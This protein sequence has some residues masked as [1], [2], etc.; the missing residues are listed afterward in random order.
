MAQP[1]RSF[2]AE[3]SALARADALPS[4]LPLLLNANDL[5]PSAPLATDTHRFLD[6]PATPSTP[7]APAPAKKKAPTH[8]TAA[9]LR[10]IKD[11]QQLQQQTIAV[12]ESVKGTLDD[13][14]QVLRSPE[15]TRGMEKQRNAAM[16]LAKGFVREALEQAQGAVALLPANPE[17]H[18]LLSLSL[19]ANAEFEPS[20]ATARKGLALVDRRQHPLAIECGL[21]HALASL[22]CAPEAIERWSAII[23]ALPLPVLFEQ[24][25]RIASCFPTDGF[26]G[27]AEVLDDLLNRRI[28]RDEQEAASV[29][30]QDR[31]DR[32]RLRDTSGKIDLRPDEIP[33]PTLFAGLDAA[34]DF[35][36]ACTHRAILAQV[37]RRLQLVKDPG[38]VVKFLSECVVPLANRGLDR[39]AGALARASVKRLLTLHADVMTLHRAMGKLELAGATVALKELATLLRGWRKARLLRARARRALAASLLLFAAGIGVLLYV[40]L[41]MNGGGLLA[42]KSTAVPVGSAAIDALWAGPGLVLLAGFAA[43]PAFAIGN[44]TLPLPENRRLLTSEENAYLHSTDL[45]R[46]IRS[47]LQSR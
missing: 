7:V 16:L 35:H 8:G 2:P 15:A 21:L 11:L 44:R 43:L 17:A 1:A 46:S 34:H 47:A 30:A 25:A 24:M 13:I 14:G 27:G 4:S 26:G 37:A 29:R 3:H 41:A 18:L 22:G 40:L 32:S 6:T 20:L 12:L 9:V 28:A 5:L 33:A 23:D 39:S 31:R 10:G 45:R 42:G 36:L 19:A 38:D